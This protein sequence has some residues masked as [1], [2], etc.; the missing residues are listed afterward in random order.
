[1]GTSDWRRPLRVIRRIQQL[2]PNNPILSMADARV[3][4]WASPRNLGEKSRPPL[5]HDDDEGDIEVWGTLTPVP[6]QPVPDWY[7]P[8]GW[9]VQDGMT[10]EAE[11]QESEV[12]TDGH[13][14]LDDFV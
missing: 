8:G 1:M 3:P 7:P 6:V 13:A 14:S 5:V 12:E 2:F 9:P 4:W 11:S 10:T